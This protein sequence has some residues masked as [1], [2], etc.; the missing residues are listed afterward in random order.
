MDPKSWTQERPFIEGLRRN[1]TPKA[2]AEMAEIKV[3]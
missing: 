1:G 2:A 3:E